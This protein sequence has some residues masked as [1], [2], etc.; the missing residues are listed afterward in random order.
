M[1]SDFDWFGA[2]RTAENIFCGDSTV[3]DIVVGTVEL[4][5]TKNIKICEIKIGTMN[6]RTENITKLAINKFKML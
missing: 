2:K 1:G 3:V 5:C 4:V 6:Q